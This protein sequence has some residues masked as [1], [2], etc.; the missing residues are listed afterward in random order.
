MKNQNNDTF[1]LARTTWKCQYRIVVTY[2]FFV[3]RSSPWKRLFSS[4]FA[5]SKILE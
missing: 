3:L 4:R 5:S 2:R 1:G